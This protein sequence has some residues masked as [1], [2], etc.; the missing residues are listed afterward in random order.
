M[1]W[2]M[3]IGSSHMKDNFPKHKSIISMLEDSHPL[4]KFAGK[5]NIVLSNGDDWKSQRKAMN[6]PFHR[7]MPIELFGEIMRKV[8]NVVDENQ[9]KPLI[10]NDLME[11]MTLDALSLG[12]FG[13]TEYT[14]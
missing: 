5:N 1:L 14:V 9:G 11:R 10:I 2:I 7:A 4:V 3:L 6:P 12:L 13:K 8:N